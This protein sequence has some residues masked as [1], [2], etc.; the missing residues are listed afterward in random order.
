MNNKH[1][2]THKAKLAIKIQKIGVGVKQK[3]VTLH[4]KA[5]YI[6]LEGSAATNRQITKASGFHQKFAI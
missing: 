1:P 5:I 3:E 2:D 6:I 4:Q